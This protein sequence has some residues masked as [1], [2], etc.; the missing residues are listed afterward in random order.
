MFSV[1]INIKIQRGCIIIKHSN[2]SI[3]IFLI[4]PKFY[5]LIVHLMWYLDQPWEEFQKC[6]VEMEH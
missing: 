1:W 4:E 6:A 3:Q 5:E 2:L